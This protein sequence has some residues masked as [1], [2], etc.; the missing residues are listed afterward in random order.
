MTANTG[1]A[2]MSAVISLD[3]LHRYRLDRA[4]LRAGPTIAFLLHNPSTADGDRDDPT[5]RRGI[6]YA[7]AWGAGRLV[8]V[9]PWAGRATKP[10]DLWKMTDPVGP[11]NDRYLHIVADEVASSGGFVVFAW[12]AVSPPPH[13]RSKVAARLRAVEAIF[14]DAGCDVR[15]LGVTKAGQPRHPLYLKADT[16][17]VAWAGNTIAGEPQWKF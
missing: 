12:G 9:N 17:P 13:L 8:Y 7:Q 16:R 10:A 15:A 3:G 4:F 1:S 5:S 14:R 6:G 11:D 2:A